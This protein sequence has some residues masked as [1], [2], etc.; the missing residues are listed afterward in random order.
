[1]VEGPNSK[2]IGGFPS[3]GQTGA[4]GPRSPFDLSVV[5][6]SQPAASRVAGKPETA[7]NHSLE[8]LGL[9]LGELRRASGLTQISVAARM[10]TTQPAL[11]R[12]EKGEFKPNL[13]TL[14]RY[15][16][17]LGQ[18]MRISFNRPDKGGVMSGSFSSDIEA[19]PKTLAAMRKE[20]GITQS[21]VAQGMETT[22]PVV[23]RLESGEF[24]PNLRTLERYAD[25]IGVQLN[26]D[27]CPSDNAQKA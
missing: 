5:P 11:A 18:E 23:A 14:V 15:A 10:G 13:S 9:R 24:A 4:A 22:Q 2:R 8:S 17:A 16:S 19:L 7:G 1:M 20:M 21:V 25:A 12:L 6:A 27:F 3:S 26:I